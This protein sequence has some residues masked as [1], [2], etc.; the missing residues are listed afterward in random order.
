MINRVIEY[1]Q[2]CQGI[3]IIMSGNIIASLMEYYQQAC[4][5]MY[6]KSLTKNNVAI[7]KINIFI[8]KTIMWPIE[9]S[10]ENPTLPKHNTNTVME[11]D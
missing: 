1:H 2:Q 3:S 6:K 4:I 8:Q 11:Y 7:K 10:E 5:S 9:Q